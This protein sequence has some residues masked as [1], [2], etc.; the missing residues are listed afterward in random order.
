MKLRIEDTRAMHCHDGSAFDHSL[1][2]RHYSLF[3]IHYSLTT[4]HT[5]QERRTPRCKGRAHAR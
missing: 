2:P 4:L 3:A 1:L 5:P